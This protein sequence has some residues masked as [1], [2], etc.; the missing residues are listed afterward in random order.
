MEQAQSPFMSEWLIGEEQ[1]R[2]ASSGSSRSPIIISSPTSPHSVDMLKDNSKE[3]PEAIFTGNCLLQLSESPL[4]RRSRPSL[5]KQPMESYQDLRQATTM[6]GKKI[7]PSKGLDSNLVR[8]QLRETVKGIGNRFGRR[9]KVETSLQFPPTLELSLTVP[10]VQLPLTTANL[11]E[12]LG[13]YMYFGEVLVLAS[14]VG[15]GMKLEKKLIVRIHEPSSGMVIKIKQ[16]LLS[17]NFEEELMSHTCYVGLTDI[18]SGWKLRDPRD[19]WLQAK[20]G[21]QATSILG[22]GIQT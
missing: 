12:W 21:S 2:K 6:S 8:S 9:P 10:S 15:P 7:L 22:Y 1:D 16:M 4:L 17:M 14:R 20:S 19:R 11:L 5:V 3:E 18:R 13:R